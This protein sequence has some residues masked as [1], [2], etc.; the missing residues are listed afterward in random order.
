MPN[1]SRAFGGPTESLIGYAR[2]A[3]SAGIDV[4]VAAPRPPGEDVAWLRE[5]MPETSFH[6]FTSV[7]RHAGVVSPGL[8]A[9]LAS[10]ASR[11]YALVHVHGL[12]NLL[13][14]VSALLCCVQDRPVL[15]RPFGTLSRYTFSRRR[16]LKQIYFRLLDRPALRR[17]RDAHRRRYHRIPCANGRR[18]GP[19]RT[20]GTRSRPFGSSKGFKP[21]GARAHRNGIFG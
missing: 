5:Q 7:G 19:C 1:A 11:E 18:G 21:G 9:W 14:S 3:A 2:A 12:F 10:D 16:L 20:H 17:A 15:I 8:W 4:G 6:F 13:S